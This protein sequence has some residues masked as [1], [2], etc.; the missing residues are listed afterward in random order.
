MTDYT[1]PHSLPIIEPAVDKIAAAGTSNLAG[2]INSLAR[3]T[4]AGLDG[5]IAD[6]ETKYG[7]LPLRVTNV[8]NRNA[9]QDGRL[10]VIEDTSVTTDATV[11]NR[12]QFVDD[13]GFEVAAIEDVTTIPYLAGSATPYSEA[14]TAGSDLE[15]MD[16]YG[17]VLFSVSDM[18][19]YP[20]LAGSA[21]PYSDLAPGDSV[22]F[23]DP[24]GELLFAV[25]GIDSDPHFR[26]SSGTGFTETHFI[27]LAGQSNSMGIGKPSPVGTNDP[28][29]NL[30]TV[31]QRGPGAG[32]QVLA[33]DPLAHPYN[34]PTPGSIGHGWTVARTYAMEHPGVRVVVLP[35]AM[36][37]SG[38]FYSGSP[39]YT[40]A[41][42]RVGEAGMTN[43]YELAISKCNAA[44]AGYT[45]IVKVPLVLWHQGE[46][47]A[48]G[49]TTQAQYEAE[50]DALIT[51]F[52]ARITGAT[53]AAVIIGQLGWEFLNIRKPGTWAQ[54]D[55]AHQATP[56][57][58]TR[59][60]FAPAP[61][62]GH[63]NADN[64]HFTG[65]GQ[66]LLAHSMISVLIDAYYNL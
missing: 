53:D 40:W 21:T 20:H 63:M 64:T 13:Y 19:G 61:P 60:A 28:L 17:A 8:E 5:V 32:T 11:S 58:V 37:G 50:L 24:Y 39:S 38:F 14:S 44:I 4:N 57:R 27:I 25:D 34:D 30:F 29:P 59:T 15:F 46:A 62:Q 22:E 9:E 31:P 33:V 45:G 54:I 3:A 1:V 7:G 36:S 12:M 52:R 51:G 35:M 47:D 23:A 26:G 65:R 16:P 42:S 49:E 56:G 18:G 55:A 6:A 66:K 43:L 2:D 48:V 10:D 41:P